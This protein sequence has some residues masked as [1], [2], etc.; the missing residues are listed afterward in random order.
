VPLFLTCLLLASSV[1]AG[2]CK[3]VDESGV[4]HYA[5]K[6]PE[7]IDAQSVKIP[8]PPAD[9]DVEAAR[10]RSETLLQESRSRAGTATLSSGF[11]SQ[12]LERLGQLPVNQLSLYL[13]TRGA[14]LAYDLENFSGQFILALRAR[15]NLPRGSWLEVLF[16]H[17]ANPDHK[18][19]ASKELRMAGAT[20][21]FRSPMS[22]D[23]KCWNY[24]IEVLIWR[25]RSKSDLLGTHRQVIQ[26]RADLSLVRNSSEMLSAVGKYGGFCPSEHHTD[27][28]G[29]NVRQLEELCE[30]EREKRLKPERE[31][32]VR[33][34]IERGDKSK[35]WCQK[36]YEDWG[37]AVRTGPATVGPALYYDLPEC[38]A[39]NE[40]RE[41]QD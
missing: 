27:M 4:T 23:L 18:N 31:R 32:L 6:C 15:D 13:E 24:E 22:R 29:M 12:P 25:D 5:E 34:C 16:P 37:S 39:A 10:A 14:D 19:V 7:G 9:E 30:Q 1:P 38:V 21:R 41:Q 8:P 40:A 3:W 36:F 20:L 35:R 11:R 17:P 26:S 2:I 28:A 33:Q